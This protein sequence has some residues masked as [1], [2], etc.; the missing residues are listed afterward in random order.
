[1]VGFVL[2]EIFDPFDTPLIVEFVTVE[3]PGIIVI[4]EVAY[5]A[6]G[7]VTRTELIDWTGGIRIEDEV[8]V[9]NNGFIGVGS[10]ITLEELI[11]ST[12][13]SDVRTGD[14]GHGSGFRD[15]GVDLGPLGTEAV[16]FCA[17][18][19]TFEFE[20]GG[21]VADGD[22]HGMGIGDD[23][24]G[25]TRRGL[26]RIVDPDYSEPR[27][28]IEGESSR[29]TAREIVQGRHY[30]RARLSRGREGRPW[31][32]TLP[33]CWEVTFSPAGITTQSFSEM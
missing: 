23:E 25:G 32:E 8:E 5:G 27:D 1:M 21:V 30:Q 13:V 24:G 18:L 12:A 2:A 17:R 33:S 3:D 16:D 11:V 10:E 7:R 29:A 6:I 14:A 4:S 22:G 9:V 28:R 26:N 15:A 20:L 19:L 31:F